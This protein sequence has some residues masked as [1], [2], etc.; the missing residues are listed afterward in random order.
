MVTGCY[1]QGRY[2]AANIDS[3]LAQ[4]YP[5]FEHIVIDSRSTDNTRE[6]CE[7]YA[8]VRYICRDDAGQ[9][10][11]LN[12]G[13]REATG[14]VIAWLNSDDYYEPGAFHRV[15]AELDPGAGRWIVAGDARMVDE[16]G[17]HLW[18]L[19][20][21]PVPFYRLLHHAHLYQAGGRTVMPCQPSVFFH[22]RVLERLGELEPDLGRAMDYEYWL[23]ALV[24]GYTFAYCPQIFSNYR[25]HASSHTAKGYDTF[26]DEWTRVFERYYAALSPAR[27]LYA[28]CWW[29]LVTVECW[30][31]RRQATAERYLDKAR[32]ARR[33]GR[34]GA[35]FRYLAA[36]AAAA[37]WISGRMLATACWNLASGGGREPEGADQ[38]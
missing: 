16:D 21:G 8:H 9:S 5:A 35:R 29:R 1:N 30:G 3:V 18:V 20:N 11:A 24:N 31:R 27:R 25:L 19:K 32:A 4:D 22:R 17:R 34:P 12:T 6:V 28:R 23:R 33:E 13:F 7:R 10:A 26:L 14:D 15:A 37:P 2:L 36:A 38:S